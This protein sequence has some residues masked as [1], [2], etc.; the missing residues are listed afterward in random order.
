M[1]RSCERLSR[2]FLPLIDPQIDKGA[3]VDFCRGRASVPARRCVF[4]DSEPFRGTP[5]G[6]E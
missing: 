4:P 1:L 3:A 6:R 5:I 2:T